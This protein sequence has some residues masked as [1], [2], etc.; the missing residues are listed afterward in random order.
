MGRQ[1][2]L[3][4][5]QLLASLA[6]LSCTASFTLAAGCS[7]GDSAR[8]AEQRRQLLRGDDLDR[9]R[10]ARL[11]KQRVTTYEGDL[12]PS[13]TRTAGVVLPR[14]FNLKFTFEY[15]WYYDGA[16]PL[17]KVEQYFTKQLD[18]EAIEH[19]DASAI[20]FAQA[21]T[22]GDK[23]MTPVSVKIFP[24][25]GRADWS[26]IYIHAPK[27]LPEHIP[28]PEEVRALLASRPRNE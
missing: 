10:N 8:R 25:P 14:G 16:L 26:R 6:L 11:E 18:F 1:H 5:S 12:L 27:P 19:P 22:K 15:E 28:T 24:V 2:R 4:R 9:Q 17:N 20:L 3:T 13:D 7:S 21:K 23:A